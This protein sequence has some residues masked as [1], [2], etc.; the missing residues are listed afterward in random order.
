MD[1][2]EI[3]KEIYFANTVLGAIKMVK[4]PMLMYEEEK[5]VVRKALSE[6]IS[7]LEDELR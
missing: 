2:E 3:N 1:R 4:T 7:K 6:Y 5:I